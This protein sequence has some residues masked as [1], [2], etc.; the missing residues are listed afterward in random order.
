MADSFHPA[1]GWEV[2]FGVPHRQGCFA[3]RRVVAG[4]HA[5]HVCV[6]EVVH[7]TGVVSVATWSKNLDAVRQRDGKCSG[8]GGELLGGHGRYCRG[9]G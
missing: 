4:S 7:Y 9:H 2:V 6:T 1:I 8:G 3:Q 5:V